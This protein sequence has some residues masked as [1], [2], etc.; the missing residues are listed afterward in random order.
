MSHVEKKFCF[1]FKDP[2][3]TVANFFWAIFRLER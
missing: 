3:C 1:S 2:G